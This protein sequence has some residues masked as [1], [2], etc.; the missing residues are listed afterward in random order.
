MSVNV[1]SASDYLRIIQ[2]PKC[3]GPVGP[4]GPQGT[5]GPTGPAGIV[6]GI[7]YYMNIKSQP[8]NAVVENGKVLSISV[9]SHGSGYTV[10]PTITISSPSSGGVTA[11][12]TSILGASSG[13]GSPVLSIT[14]T[15]PGSGYI[16]VPTVTISRGSGDTTG[17]GATANCVISDYFKLSI[18]PPVFSDALNSNYTA[19]NSAYQYT[20]FYAQV[21]PTYV[22]APGAYPSSDFLLASFST[23][24][25]DLSA[26]SV[27]PQGTWILSF[28]AYSFYSSDTSLGAAGPASSV[29]SFV[30]AVVSITGST[31]NPVLLG[32]SR[33]VQIDNK[34]TTA[35]YTVNIPTIENFSVQNPTLDVLN[36]QI[37]IPR[38]G[39]TAT[40]PT[41]IQYWAGGDSISQIVTSFPPAGGVMGSTGPS[42]P[43]G[44]TGA[45]GVQ[46]PTG[47]RGQDGS[48]GS[49]GTNGQTGATGPA[50]TL[51]PGVIMQYASNTIPSGW[52]LCDGSSFTISQYPDLY[53]VITNTYGGTSPTFNVPN[54]SGRMTVGKGSAPFNGLGYLGGSSTTTLN[55]NQLP[56]HEHTFGLSKYGGVASVSSGGGTYVNGLGGDPV[57]KTGSVIYDTNG[58]AV[59]SQQPVNVMN[60][61]IVLNYI[62]KT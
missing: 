27:I 45:S 52:L 56:P 39:I 16:T 18:T 43:R 49:N 24:P 6:T 4:T 55:T 37:Y 21:K 57:G 32:R 13:L 62:I 17:S 38:S 5:T 41:T 51:P 20:G 9:T 8:P 14:I 12:A 35:F 2:N 30:Y 1:V 48:N 60:P 61:Y 50:G 10:T 25:G 46:G 22:A 53:A 3:T 44:L 11:T 40:G 36:V 58:N 47:P 54:L 29:D 23:N 7:T 33:G 15:N 42:G 34:G 28:N 59:G 31:S 19:I 26:Y